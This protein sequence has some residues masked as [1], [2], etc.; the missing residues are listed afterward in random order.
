MTTIDAK[1]LHFSQLG[2]SLRALAGQEVQVKNCLGHRYIG[3]GISGIS[4]DIDGIPGN[5]LGAYLLEGSTIVTRGNAQDAT[6]DTMSGG[7]IV[8]HGSTGDAVGYGMRGGSIFVKGNAGYRAGIHMK[9]FGEK[10]P[11]L[12]IGGKAGDF[13]GEYQAGGIIVV[14]GL[15]AKQGEPCVGRF[16]GTGQHGGKI[17]LRG[18]IVPN[19]LPPQVFVKQTEPE[20]LE[21]IVPLLEQYAATFGVDLGMLKSSP[22]LLLTPNSA[23]PYQSLYAQY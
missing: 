4:I 12:V 1:A 9:E 10:C 5:A 8:I 16:C 7:S 23:N 22:Y 15:N 20:D 11:K 13:L 21:P 14:L 18:G 17:F 6:G 2:E 19:E 3:A